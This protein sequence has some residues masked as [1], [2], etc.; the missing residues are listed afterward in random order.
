MD[1]QL[2][3]MRLQDLEQMVHWEK[4]EDPLFA[5]YNFPSYS[6]REQKLWLSSKTKYGKICLTILVDKKVVGYISIRKM[7]PIAKSAEMGII[8]RPLYQNMGL[9][10]KA[11]SKM[12][13]WFFGEFGY[14]KMSLY[15]GR[16]NKKAF[17]C[18]HK[19]GFKP[20]KE[21]YLAFENDEVNL[22]EAQYED[23]RKF[24]RKK[25]GKTQTLCL[26]MVL[27]KSNVDTNKTTL[28]T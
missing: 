12:L 26:H 22:E 19:L 3:N 15:V 2:R 16:Y 7:N 13:D 8:I 6:P 4:N 11:I 9:G 21:V 10:E 1:I 28:G 24:F 5:D 25:N 27:E 18:Y 23:I 14:K 17:S 20:I